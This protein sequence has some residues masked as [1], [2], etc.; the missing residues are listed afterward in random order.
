[1]PRIYREQFVGAT[2]HVMNRGTNKADVFFSED[3]KK[4][5]FDILLDVFEKNNVDLHCYC[6]MD[7]HYHLL[8]TTPDANLSKVMQLLVSKY[9]IMINKIFERDGPLF[10]GRFKSKIIDSDAYM[11]DVAKYIHKN[12]SIAGICKNDVNFNWSS[13]KF[14]ASDIFA[15][16]SWL[17]MDELLC[18]FGN[19]KAKFVKYCEEKDLIET[20]SPYQFCSHHPTI[21]RT[22]K[23]VSEHYSLPYGFYKFNHQEFKVANIV[24]FALIDINQRY[25]QGQKSEFF[26]MSVHALRSKFS[27]INIELEQNDY[28][29]SEI[30]K[31]KEKLY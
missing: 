10:R 30:E 14:Y 21:D 27:K 24:L 18:Y 22:L 29:V 11:I 12:P 9:T 15:N 26:A 28:L 8:L 5:F 16:P 4:L 1:M 31:L 19:S 7:N 2:Y 17:S 25:N 6:L 20:I 13:Y 23:V 3:C